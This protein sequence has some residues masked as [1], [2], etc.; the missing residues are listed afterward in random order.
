MVLCLEERLEVESVVVALLLK[1]LRHE[2][3][4]CR[5]NCVDIGYALLVI[6]QVVNEA[7]HS[8]VKELKYDKIK[9][10]R[11]SV[12]N[13]EKLHEQIFGKEPKSPP[14]PRPSKLRTEV[15][16]KKVGKSPVVVVAR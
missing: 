9:H 8:I 2:D 4:S 1:Y 3:W 11:D 12:N 13:Y 10:V 14:P 6:N 15:P 16:S 7:V 5:K